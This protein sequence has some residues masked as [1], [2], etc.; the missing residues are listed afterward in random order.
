MRLDALNQIFFL[1]HKNADGKSKPPSQPSSS[2]PFSSLCLLPS[3]HLQFM[4]GLFGLDSHETNP[5]ESD[6]STH[7]MVR[8]ER[9]GLGKG[10]GLVLKYGMGGGVVESEGLEKAS[11]F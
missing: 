7:Y 11:M 1:L 2:V 6:K 5:E 3:V 9:R 4:I 10:E 8:L